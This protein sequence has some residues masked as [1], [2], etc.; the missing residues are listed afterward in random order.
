[1]SDQDRQ[2]EWD[3]NR[4]TELLLTGYTWRRVRDFM[5]LTKEDF[6]VLLDH[7]VVKAQRE[8]EKIETESPE[9]S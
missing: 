4:L 7:A 6:D 8:R 5:H 2:H 3:V 1:M 9:P